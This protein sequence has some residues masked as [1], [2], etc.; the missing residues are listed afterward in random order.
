MLTA[1]SDSRLFLL[2]AVAL[3]GVAWS[4]LLIWGGSRYATY[5]HHE[6]LGRVGTPLSKAFSF[7]LG[8]IGR[9]SCRER[10]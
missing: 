1:R 8:E 4:A 7:R 5:L 9:A 3:I 10:V 6:A 2:V